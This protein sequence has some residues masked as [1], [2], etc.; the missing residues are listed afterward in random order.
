MFDEYK[1]SKEMNRCTERLGMLFM[2]LADHMLM[3]P[4]FIGYSKEVKEDL[5]GLALIRL[6]K[7]IDNVNLSFNP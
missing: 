3:G 4:R 1:K 5:K 7:S 6:I 2:I